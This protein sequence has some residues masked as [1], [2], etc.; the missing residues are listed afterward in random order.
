MWRDFKCPVGLRRRHIYYCEGLRSKSQVILIENKIGRLLQKGSK[1]D[2]STMKDNFRNY[3]F[4][5]YQQCFYIIDTGVAL[6]LF[7]QDTSRKG[8]IATLFIYFFI[9]FALLL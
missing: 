2:K 7:L 4:S 8:D 6:T 5:L 9:I 3:K 1:N